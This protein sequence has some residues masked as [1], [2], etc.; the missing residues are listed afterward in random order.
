MSA[1]ELEARL[2][3]GCE[4]FEGPLDLLLALVRREGYPLDRLPVA[5]LTAQFLAAVAQLRSQLPAETL[6]DS[7]TADMLAAF[8]ETASW[9][10]LLKS[11][12]LLPPTLTAQEPDAPEAEL[13]RALLSH[14]ALRQAAAMLRKR[15]E[16][17][18]LPAATPHSRRYP[19]VPLEK[20]ARELGTAVM[21]APGT[22]PTIADAVRSARRALDVVR[23]RPLADP[24][25][26]KGELAQLEAL[27][28]LL[29]PGQAVPCT[30]WFAARPEPAAQAALLL[31]LLE[32][33]R[34]GHVLL[35]QS[36]DFGPVSLKRIEASTTNS[37]ETMSA[38]DR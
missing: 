25:P 37:R 10:V 31:A 3:G 19:E 17:A 22:Q 14:A 15:M 35:H 30:P 27:L 20:T 8:A 34:L 26:M 38:S 21:P 13:S 5:R 1:F 2:A 29:T 12:S 4:P 32:L 7:E 23:A 33:A 18:G 24:F 11:R 6:G 36:R 9:L 28:A 16:A